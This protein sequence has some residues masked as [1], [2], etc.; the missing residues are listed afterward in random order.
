[1]L[2]VTLHENEAG[3]STID[4]PIHGNRTDWRVN[5][6]QRIV[7]LAEER[8]DTPNDVPEM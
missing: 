8:P 4:K 6:K 2:V 1:M 5:D 3:L 7:W